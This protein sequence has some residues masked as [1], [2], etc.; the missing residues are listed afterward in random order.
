MATF[1][2][3][4]SETLEHLCRVAESSAEF[5]P[6]A[7]PPE[8]LI[9]ALWFDQQL[10]HENL[11]TANGR[12]IEVVSPGRWNSGPGPDFKEAALRLNGRS[13][14]TGDIEVE[15]FSSD[16]RRHGHAD[17]EDFDDVILKVCMWNDEPSSMR[18][19][20]PVLELFPYVVDLRFLSPETLDKY[21]YCSATLKG[22]C[23][24]LVE[25]KQLEKA[26]AFIESAGDS[27]I[28]GK[29]AR[30]ARMARTFGY[31]QTLF[32]GLMEAMG[33]SENKRQMNQI[34]HKVPLSLIRQLT[35]SAQL[36][37]RQPLILALFYTYCGVFEEGY[38]ET[39]D[40]LDGL[41]SLAETNAPAAAGPEELVFS[42]TR[43]LNNPLRRLVAVSHIL[44]RIN[45]LKLFDFFISLLGK[46]DEPSEENARAALKRIS[47]FFTSVRDPFWDT[48]L[49]FK[50]GEGS[51][52]YALTGGNLALTIT[53][54]VLIPL[55]LA[56]ARQKQ[57]WNL[58]TFLHQMLSQAN[59]LP[60]NRKTRFTCARLFGG[61]LTTPAFAR[62]ARVHQ[63]LIQVYEDFCK[64]LRKECPDCELMTF[65]ED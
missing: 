57:W 23:R 53:A 55:M 29:A 7:R 44:D 28:D 56:W 43:P 16:W 47:G 30:L 18:S 22:R 9:S 32:I 36:Q 62:N 63:G 10:D 41:R 3:H 52:R 40:Y 1:L 4:Y 38:G 24:G 39:N 48:R 27:R 58:E 34:A 42:R 14:S 64:H 20:I 19:P 37:N 11:K 33:Y 51:K 59:G 31:D 6:A 54:N 35:G 65:F 15:V 8:R 50:S 46:V 21:P 13:I 45:G 49:T 61:D 60:H 26:L 5:D 2:T 12:R 17:N 25:E